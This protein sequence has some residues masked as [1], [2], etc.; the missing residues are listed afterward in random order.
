MTHRIVNVFEIINVKEQQSESTI[1][2]ILR[3]LLKLLY[4][5]QFIRQITQCI[6]VRQLMKLFLGILQ[7]IVLLH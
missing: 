1:T 2:L 6:A 7:L 3:K 5:R 4:E